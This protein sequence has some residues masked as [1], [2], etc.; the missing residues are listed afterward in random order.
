MKDLNSSSAI[1]DYISGFD[2]PTTDILQKIRFLVRSLI[3]E[4]RETISYGIPT[5]KLKKNLVHFAGYKNHIGFYPTP[6]VIEHF[7][8]ELSGYKTAKGSVQ[9]SLNNPIP[10]DLIE[11]MV[12]Y[13]IAQIK[14][15]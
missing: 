2:P 7:K 5:F 13:R 9:F 12:R 14:G 6:G 11:K 4:A 1:D 3:P 8:T 15:G 10:Y